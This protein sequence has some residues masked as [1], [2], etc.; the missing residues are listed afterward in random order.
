MSF[1]TAGALPGAWNSALSGKTPLEEG[2]A[3]SDNMPVSPDGA[4]NSVCCSIIFPDRCLNPQSPHPLTDSTA[5]GQDSCGLSLPQGRG[6]K[7][8]RRVWSVLRSKIYV[9]QIPSSGPQVSHLKPELYTAGELRRHRRSRG[10]AES[11]F[12]HEMLWRVRSSGA[13]VSS[14]VSMQARTMSAA[15]GRTHSASARL[16]SACSSG[17][18]RREELSPPSSI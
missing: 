6:C 3:D 16:R 14:N 11:R 4:E 2:C 13:A 18:K 12:A 15:R 7:K 8:E 1:A 9:S 10:A 5:G 17:R